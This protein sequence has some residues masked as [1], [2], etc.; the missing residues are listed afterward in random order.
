MPVF[1]DACAS[2]GNLFCIFFMRLHPAY[3]P[4]TRVGFCLFK[5]NRWIRSTVSAGKSCSPV[6][7]LKF[8]CLQLRSECICRQQFQRFKDAPLPTRVFTKP[9][10]IGALKTGIP[11]QFSHRSPERSP[12]RSSTLPNRARPSRTDFSVSCAFCSISERLCS[13]NRWRMIS[14]NKV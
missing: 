1:P 12:R 9:F 6:L 10:P 14:I 5:I 4:I 2:N 7:T 11:R 8:V 3:F 13:S